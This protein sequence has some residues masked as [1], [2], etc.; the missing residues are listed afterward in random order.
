[1][2]QRIRRCVSMF[3]YKRIPWN[4]ATNASRQG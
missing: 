3:L 4:V 2:S 1:M